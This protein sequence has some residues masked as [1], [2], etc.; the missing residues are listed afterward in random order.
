M[1]AVDVEDDA[2]AVDV[3]DDAEAVDVEDDAE[4]VGVEDDAGEDEDEIVE[5]EVNDDEVAVKSVVAFVV[6]VD[7]ACVV[8]DFDKCVQMINICLNDQHSEFNP[9][10]SMLFKL[11]I[12]MV[13]K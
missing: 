8:P 11:H 1:E 7:I 13:T 6:V 12:H 9:Y 2:E 3:E 5:A 10:S 4:A